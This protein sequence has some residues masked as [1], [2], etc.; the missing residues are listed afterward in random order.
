LSN[1]F[2]SDKRR[3]LR[4]EILDY[5]QAF[6]GD[7][8]DS[9]NCVI[10]DIGLGGLQLRSKQALPVGEMCAIQV[11]RLDKSPL[12]LKGEVRHCG[13]IDDS[14]LYASGIRFM[15]QSHMDRMAIAEYVHEIFQ[16]QCDKLLA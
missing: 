5:A 9:T 8:T 10:V 3:Y 13:L 16:R 7:R 4:Y 15:P 12:I 2:G 1:N 6:C 11:G 14:D